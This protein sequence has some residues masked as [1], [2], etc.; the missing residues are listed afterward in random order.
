[1]NR[2]VLIGMG[3]LACLGL[4]ATIAQAQQPVRTLDDLVGIRASSG[5]QQMN[6]RGY[7]FVRG[8]KAGDSSYTY[9][10]EP[11]TNKC[12]AVRTTNGEYASLVYASDTDC[13]GGS[14]SQMP[15][16]PQTEDSFDTVCGVEAGGQTHRYRCHVRVE[17]CKGEGY[18]R[19]VLTFPDLEL[20]IN[21]HK[22]D[23][24]TIE[25]VGMNPQDST[26]SFSNGQTRFDYGGNTY[27][28]YRTPDRAK[29]E[30]ANFHE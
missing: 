18:C 13:Q 4:A 12:V 21:W 27:F 19:N 26:A 20:R 16:S 15:A 23:R 10:R 11:R 6:S 9:W 5:E 1:M 14:A 29:R 7:T 28:F 17:G 8:E 22:D 25:S 2:K 24:I 3:L 30:L